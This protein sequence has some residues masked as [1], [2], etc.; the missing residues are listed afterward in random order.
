M[1]RD[2]QKLRA[3]YGVG[4][5]DISLDDIDLGGSPRIVCFIL[6]GTGRWAKAR[7]I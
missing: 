4:P 2:D 6:Y 7:G 1:G 5:A 3:Y